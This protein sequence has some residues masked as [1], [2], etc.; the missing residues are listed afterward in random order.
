MTEELM[1]LPSEIEIFGAQTR[2]IGIE[3]S[4]LGQYDWYILHNNGTDRVRYSVAG[5]VSRGWFLRS[6]VSGDSRLFCGVR[7]GEYA[8]VAGVVIAVSSTSYNMP[9]PF[10]AI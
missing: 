4:P 7:D 6:P 10:F 8:P 3:E 5:G 9:I 1:F 2:S